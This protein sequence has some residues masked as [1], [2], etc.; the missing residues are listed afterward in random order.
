[1]H[2]LTRLYTIESWLAF[3]AG[4]ALLLLV[5]AVPISA[6]SGRPLFRWT[7]RILALVAVLAFVSWG[8]TNLWMRHILR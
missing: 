6:K 3:T 8:A 7:V 4:G 1:M 2:S 5:F